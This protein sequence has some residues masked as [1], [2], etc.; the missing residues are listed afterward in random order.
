MEIDPLI[1]ELE[2]DRSSDTEGLVEKGAKTVIAFAGGWPAET[3]DE[4]RE[5]LAQLGRRILEARPSVA[6]LFHLVTEV[7]ACVGDSRDLSG[8]RRSI[9]TA[10]VEFASSFGSRVDKVAGRAVELLERGARVM[11]VGRSRTLERALLKAVDGGLLTG[12]VISECRP[13]CFGRSLAAELGE[14]GAPGIRLVADFALVNYLDDVDLLLFGADCVRAEGA[15]TAV[16]TSTVAG[17]A[18][19]KGKPAYLLAGITRILPGEAALP[20]PRSLGDPDD[21]WADPPPGVAVECVS[22]EIAPLNLFKGFVMEAGP[23]TPYEMEQRVKST[24]VPPWVR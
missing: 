6:P 2:S 7:Y 4:L 10:A 20:A 22:D 18:R 24:P 9:R 11:T 19:A 14:A 13:H 15:V 12:A 21:L 1:R 23:I 5:G 8:V 16:G 17:A 3:P